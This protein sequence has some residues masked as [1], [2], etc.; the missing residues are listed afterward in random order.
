M[1]E[2][3]KALGKKVALALSHLNSYPHE[4]L[5]WRTPHDVFVEMHG[6]E[7]RAFLAKL[8]IVRIYFQN[9]RL[10]LEA[11]IVRSKTTAA[12]LTQKDAVLALRVGGRFGRICGCSPGTGRA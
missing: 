8:G 11:A 9:V 1:R 5:G 2:R 4:S 12:N 10:L 3:L 6:D 7:G